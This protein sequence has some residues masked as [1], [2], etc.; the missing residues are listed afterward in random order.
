[1]ISCMGL[2]YLNVQRNSPLLSFAAVLLCTLSENKLF[3][4]TVSLS[5]PFLFSVK[6]LT[7]MVIQFTVYVRLYLHSF[8]KWETIYPA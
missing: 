4:G 5:P 6:A 8:M 3:F 7:N 1:M 2:F